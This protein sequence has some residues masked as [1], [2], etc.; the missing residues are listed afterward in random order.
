M[1]IM[2]IDK[3]VI[4][5]IVENQFGVLA[6]IAGMFSSR[7]YNISSLIVGETEDPTISLMTITVEG[8]EDIVEQVIKQ[9][10]KQINVI[11]VINLTKQDYISRELALVK[12]SANKQNRHKVI[13]VVQAMGGEII[14]VTKLFVFAEFTGDEDKVEN[15]IQLIKSYGI[16]EMIRTGKVA[17]LK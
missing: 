13:A 11:K 6:Q 8:N 3:H 1:N 9:L 17:L 7:G 5:V 2:K 15:A 12:V 14:E 10:N 16:K 4:N